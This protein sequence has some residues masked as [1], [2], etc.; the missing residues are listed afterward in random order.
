MGGGYIFIFSSMY[1]VFYVNKIVII[2]IL[3]KVMVFVLY[4]LKYCI[5]IYILSYLFNS[6]IWR[7][8]VCFDGENV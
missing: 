8:F 7:R 5:D 2:I 1:N 6:V 3:K 4:L